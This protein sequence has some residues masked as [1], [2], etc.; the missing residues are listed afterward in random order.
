MTECEVITRKWGNSLG[1]TLPKDI[2][3]QQHIKENEEIRV[4]IL[5]KSPVIRKNFGI[6]KGKLKKDTQHLMDNVRKEIHGA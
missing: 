2:V 4:I 5:K 3:E 6:L 1:I